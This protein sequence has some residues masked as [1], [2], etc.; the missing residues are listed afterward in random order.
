MADLIREMP[1][2]V[3]RWHPETKPLPRR[4]VRIR[5][6]VIRRRSQDNPGTTRAPMEA[7]SISATALAGSS[8]TSWFDVKNGLIYASHK[9]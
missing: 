7:R 6:G 1:P 3:Y 2:L 8:T 4:A 5:A 9:S